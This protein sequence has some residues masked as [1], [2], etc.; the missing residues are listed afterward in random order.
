MLRMIVKVLRMLN[1]NATDV[2]TF[3]IVWPMAT[4]AVIANKGGLETRFKGKLPSL[5]FH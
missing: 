4:A 5:P 1:T 3:W 2:E